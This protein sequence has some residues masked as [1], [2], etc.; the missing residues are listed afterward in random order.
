MKKLIA[1][2]VTLIV[3]VGMVFADSQSL[4][5]T[6]TISEQVP[7]FLMKGGSAS[8]TYGVSAGADS[9]GNTQDYSYNKINLTGDITSTNLV[10][11]FQVLQNTKANLSKV[12]NFTVYAGNLVRQ[13]HLATEAE[14]TANNQLT[15]GTSVVADSRSYTITT[16][17]TVSAATKNNTT[18]ALDNITIAPTANSTSAAFSVTYTGNVAGTELPLATF[19]VTWTKDAAAMDGVYMADVTLT[20][21]PQ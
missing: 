3:L 13:G 9:N 19:S 15:A 14:A 12:F 2:L 6:T 4:T 16:G 11:Y 5:V 7:T 21:T 1:I 20:V 18:D 10:G 8:G 17:V